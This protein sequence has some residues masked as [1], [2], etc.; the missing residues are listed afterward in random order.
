MDSNMLP[1][2]LA[3]LTDLQ[4]RV[5]TQESTIQSL[6]REVERLGGKTFTTPNKNTE[7]MRTHTQ[8]QSYPPSQMHSSS[9]MQSYP[10]NTH[11][12]RPQI[13]AISNTG[14]YVEHT[15]KY[16]SKKKHVHIEKQIA[17]SDLLK[18][19]EEVTFEIGIGKNEEGI[20]TIGSC[21]T[22]YSDGAFTVT[23]CPLMSSFNG[24]T[25]DKPGALLYKFLDLMRD[26]GVCKWKASSV[27]PWKYCSVQR[28]GKR[29]T[30]EQ[31]RNEMII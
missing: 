18:E 5:T 23:D 25:F 24:Q 1:L 2:I 15:S 3:Q 12:K 22:K 17:C 19:G 30:L 8:M 11:K 4:M 20:L 13:G 9:Q 27:A 10:S 28:N 31:L 26:S 21:K 7:T 29:V 6:K 16:D 14:P